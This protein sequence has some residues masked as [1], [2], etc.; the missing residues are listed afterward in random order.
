M[1]IALLLLNHSRGLFS[2]TNSE[3]FNPYE[4]KI[5]A[6]TF[7]AIA[8]FKPDSKSEYS[9]TNHILLGYI[10]EQVEGKPYSAILKERIADKLDLKD[11]YYGGPVGDKKNE[12]QSY[13][14][15]DT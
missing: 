4:A 11:T 10:L 6:E 15:T 9:N 3:T 1:G 2:V 5:P 12:A 13:E 14:F 8:G 7:A